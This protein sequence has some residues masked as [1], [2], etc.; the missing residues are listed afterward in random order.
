M[1]DG[2]QLIWLFFRFSGRIGRLPYALASLFST[3]VIVFVI[4]KLVMALPASYFEQ[5]AAGNTAMADLPPTPAVE[6]W[7]TLTVFVNIVFDWCMLALTAKR[8]H[9]L[10]R[11]G[12][13]SLLLFLGGLFI[14]LILSFV[15]GNPGPNRFGR[16]PDRPG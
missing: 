10:G 3:I 11:T 8:M 13:W 14:P 4:Y 15:P 2:P 12:W 16:R 1:A 6:F 9:D 5:A 7:A